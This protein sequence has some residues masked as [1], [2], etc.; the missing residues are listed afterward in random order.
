MLISS[1]CY[2]VK[3]STIVAIILA[4][5]AVWLQTGGRPVK[6][7]P[8]F[9]SFWVQ[10][11]GESKMEVSAPVLGTL[12]FSHELAFLLGPHLARL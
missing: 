8:E 2:E 3:V 6:R 1:S 9:I 12:F 5:P 10:P 11:V 7:A 4:F